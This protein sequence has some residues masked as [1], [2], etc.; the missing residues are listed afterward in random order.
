MQTDPSPARTWRADELDAALEGLLELD[1]TLK[2]EG[3]A[4]SRRRRLAFL[5]WV[6]E[7]AAR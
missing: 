2:G 5:V 4:D 6:A 7:R 1:A 3:A